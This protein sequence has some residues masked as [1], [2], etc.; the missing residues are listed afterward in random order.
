MKT[1]GIVDIL[2]ALQSGTY[3][4]QVVGCCRCGYCWLSPLLWEHCTGQASAKTPANGRTELAT[5][6]GLLHLRG[7]GPDPYT[8]ET[9]LWRFDFSKEV[10]GGP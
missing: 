5:G 1:S 2:R 7:H 9:E 4:A 3:V 10:A 6:V 8:V